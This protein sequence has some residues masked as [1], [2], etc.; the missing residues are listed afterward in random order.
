MFNR[1]YDGQLWSGSLWY[2]G[3][4]NPSATLGVNGDYYVNSLN[5]SIYRKNQDT[6]EIITVMQGAQGLAGQNLPS[7]GS[8]RQLLFK[9]SST[10]YDASWRALGQSDV[11]SALGYLPLSTESDTLLS[12]T[13]RGSVTSAA[14]T[15]TNTTDSTSI[16]TGALRISGGMGVEKTIRAGSFVGNLTGDVTGNL[17]GNLTGTLYGRLTGNATATVIGNVSGNATAVTNAVLTTGNYVDPTWLTITASKIGLATVA[18]SG[19]YNDLSN[20][21]SAY[22]LPLASSSTLGGVRVDGTTITVDPVTGV[23]SGYAGYTLPTATPSVLGG[24][25]IDG[26]TITINGSGVISSP[27]YTLPAATTSTLGGIRV[28]GTSVLVDG[29]GIISLATLALS[30]SSITTAG[31]V[32]LNPSTIVKDGNNAITFVSLTNNETYYTDKI[33]SSDGLEVGPRQEIGNFPGIVTRK[34]SLFN[35]P[36]GESDRRAIAFDPTGEF[37]ISTGAAGTVGNNTKLYR[38]NDDYCDIMSNNNLIQGNAVINT[39]TTPSGSYFRV[40]WH[41]T[42]RYAFT[43]STTNVNLIALTLGSAPSISQNQTVSFVSIR[44]LLIHPTGKVLYLCRTTGIDINIVQYN[45]D[46][47][48]NLS[49]VLGTFNAGN[50]ADLTTFS[51][52]PGGRVIYATTT[53]AAS[54]LRVFYLSQTTFTI[55]SQATLTSFT[56]FN[57]GTVGHLWH[58]SG[59][60]FF[61]FADDNQNMLC[62]RIDESG[63]FIPPYFIF[64]TSTGGNLGCVFEPS[65]NYMI[66]LKASGRDV[67]ILTFT[68]NDIAAALTLQRN[69]NIGNYNQLMT[70][71]TMDPKGRYFILSRETRFEI[72]SL[73]RFRSGNQNALVTRAFDKVAATYTVSA[74]MIT[75]TRPVLGGR[76]YDKQHLPVFQQAFGSTDNLTSLDTVRKVV[77]HPNGKFHYILQASNGFMLVTTSFIT[78]NNTFAGQTAPSYYAGGIT[79][80]DIRLSVGGM[81]LFAC[82]GTGVNTVY[83]YSIDQATGVPTQRSTTSIGSGNLYQMCVH[84]SNQYLYI[85][86]R[87]TGDVYK[88]EI[89]LN[90]TSVSLGAR[91]TII[92]GILIAPENIDIDPSGRVLV[93]CNTGGNQVNWHLL[94]FQGNP[95]SLTQ[96]FVGLIAYAI[97]VDPQG[98][99]MIF[100][101]TNGNMYFYAID[102]LTAEPILI[103]SIIVVH[104][105]FSQIPRTIKFDSTGSYFYY[106][107]HTNNDIDVFQV[108]TH[109]NSGTL[110]R[111]YRITLSS[112]ATD[113]IVDSTGKSLIGVSAVTSIGFTFYRFNNKNSGFGFANLNRLISTS[114]MIKSQVNNALTTV[115]TGSNQLCLNYG[116]SSIFEATVNFSA[117]FTVNIINVPT[118]RNLAARITLV[119]QNT[120]ATS[121]FYPNQFTING[122]ITNVR[123]HGT[124]TTLT[125]GV[126]NAWVIYEI[127]ILRFGGT[128]GQVVLSEPNIGDAYGGGYYGGKISTSGDGVATHYLIVSPA[129][130]G[131]NVRQWKTTNTTTA[132]TSSVIDGPTNSANMNDASHPAA[133]FCEDLSIGG[134]SDW[135]MPA[136]NELE[137]CYYNL[138]PTTTSNSTGVGINTNAVPSRGS[139]YTSGTPAQTAVTDFK[140]GGSQAFAATYYWS[141]TQQQ[142]SSSWVQDF[143][144][145]N[146][147]FALKTFSGA[148]VRAIRRVPIT[149]GLDVEVHV[150]L[151]K[152]N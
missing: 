70:N 52:D 54:V 92:S 87:T 120:N 61:Q 20:R 45:V 67:E 21:P 63:N 93:I 83:F 106:P 119:L 102:P 131:E 12:V 140:S 100:G 35:N 22:T 144:D 37:L 27:I 5:N 126:Q 29:S 3:V 124:A 44:E 59:K 114:R 107:R 26:T 6:W 40:V 8:F 75:S 101:T 149:S 74:G 51:I 128:K 81:W 43:A 138:K 109:T 46:N 148:R 25:L 49:N 137:V 113:V 69:I 152:W 147:L 62:N 150:R 73:D 94:D 24:V 4:V 58:P 2:S 1:I 115:W 36:D 19:S 15:I 7:G 104:T 129:S 127:D 116:L 111:I 16:G 78:H 145:G 97:G 98:R 132:G 133:Q 48:G 99:Y 151:P 96:T 121:S 125:G 135:Y 66:A 77:S 130:S 13:T 32:S 95:Y 34:L 72:Y 30:P 86:D 110:V 122:N 123:F 143:S 41:P 10:A 139:N 65:G 18:T 84:P 38:L 79:L 142:A 117:N 108:S 91:T 141:S 88:Q 136:Q 56:T 53:S 39:T 17:T 55:S 9:N 23:T 47:K 68:P 33:I 28:D 134:Y 105:A 89:T 82:A 103:R 42:E 60:F 118:D 90:I 76:G 11:T 14:I 71:I 31:A 57:S 50:A 112:A 64:S 80:T 146:Q 85:L